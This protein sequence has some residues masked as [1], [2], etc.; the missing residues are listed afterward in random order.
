MTTKQSLE[1]MESLFTAGQ[2]FP[3]VL[4]S[5]VSL[6]RLS[7]DPKL[8]APSTHLS[9]TIILVRSNQLLPFLSMLNVRRERYN[10]LF[11]KLALG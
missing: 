9:R 7:E 4:S 11:H 8:T 5:A 3:A 10:F 6:K 1:R 2:I